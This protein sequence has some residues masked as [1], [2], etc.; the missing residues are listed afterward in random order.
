MGAPQSAADAADMKACKS[1]ASRKAY[2][3][4]RR[5]MTWERGEEQTAWITNW[6]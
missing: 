1:L 5:G 2:A 6:N 4:P 3:R